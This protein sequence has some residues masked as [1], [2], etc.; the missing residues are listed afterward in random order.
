LFPH[1][2]RGRE[3][4][5]AAKRKIYIRRLRTLPGAA[6]VIEFRVRQVPQVEPV[7]GKEPA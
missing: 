7:S 6:K 5:Y 1:K 2:G 4:W 3:I